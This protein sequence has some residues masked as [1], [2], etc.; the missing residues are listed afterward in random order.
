[1]CYKKVCYLRKNCKMVLQHKYFLLSERYEILKI[2]GRK[3]ALQ[4]KKTCCLDRKTLSRST[5][6][7]AGRSEG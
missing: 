3:P 6:S 1:M 7:S 2:E 5:P 4:L